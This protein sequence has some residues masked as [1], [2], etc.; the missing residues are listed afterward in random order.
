[1]KLG[2]DCL[3]RR[4]DLTVDGQP[5]GVTDRTRRS[6]IAT[7]HLRQF[8]CQRQIV[9]TLN[10][11]AHGNDDICFTQVYSLFHFLEWR[12]RSHTNLTYFN[13]HVLYRGPTS[14]LGLI[15]PEGPGLKGS[16]HRRRAI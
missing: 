13:W 8:F 10:A 14:L 15:R 4:S 16:K 11:A 12:F 9:F 1:I 2:R 5:L 6:E 7:E 3:A